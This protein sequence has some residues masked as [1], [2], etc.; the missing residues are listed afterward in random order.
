[1]NESETRWYQ[2]TEEDA[3]SRLD[4]EPG[5]LTFSEAEKRLEEHGP[6]EIEK[7]EE[8]TWI[9]VLVAQIKNPLILVL[10]VAAG[11]SLLAGEAVD[12]IVIV[13]VIVVN[14]LIGFVQEY[15]AEKSLEALQEQAAPEA[16]VVRCSVEDGT[17]ESIDV[18]IPSREVVPGDIIILSTGDKV[19][20]DARLLQVSSLEVD[21][22]ML[23]G[24]STPVQKVIEP[25]EEEAPVAEQQN[26]VFGG[27]T[28]TQ[29]H[30][31]ALVFATG[32][33][34]E[35]GKIATMIQE[36]EDVESPLQRQ[37]RDLSRKMGFL[38]LGVAIVTVLLGLIRGFEVAEIFLFA[39]A[40]AVSS[41]PAGLPAVMTIT[42]AVG[43]NRMAKRNA[44]I[45]R[46]QAV[47]TLGAATTICTDKTGTLTSNQMTVQQIS[48][49]HRSVRITGVG[50]EPE[51]R[52]E[53]DEEEVDPGEDEELHLAL[54]IGAL[55]N[56]SRLNRHDEEGQHVWEIR[57]DPT[58]GALVVAAAKAHQHKEN[59]EREFPRTDEIPFSSKTKFMATFHDLPDDGN[60]IRV[61]VKGAPETVLGLSAQRRRNGEVDSLS[62]SQEQELGDAAQ[63]MASQGLRVLGLAYLDIAKEDVEETRRRLEDGEKIMT[64]HALAGM[65]DP[66]RPEVPEAIERAKGAGMRVIMATG[67]HRLTAEAIADEID[68]LTEDGQVLTGEDV[69][70][71]DDEELERQVNEVDVFARVSPE[72]KH[73]MVEALRRSGEVVAMTGDG[74]ND[75]PALKAAEIGIAMGITGTDVTKET[76][77][78]VL[79]DDNFASIVNAVEEGRVVFQNIRKVVKLLIATNFGEILT[80]L[81]SIVLL[82]AGE[83][84]FLPVQILWV[85]LV[86]DGLLDVTLAMEPKEEDV[87]EHKP[88]DPEARIINLEIARNTLFVAL[89]MAIGTLG[90]FFWGFNDGEIAFA[91]T[92][93]F[94]TLAM[95]QVFNALNCRSL[96][97]S[98]FQ[99]GLFTN[100]YLIGAIV[101]SVLLQIG[102]TLIPFMQ[103]AMQTVPLSPA[104][105]LTIVLIASTVF[106]ADE[107]RKLVQ[108][109]A[110]ND[111]S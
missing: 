13:A 11:I 60:S 80:F 21:E 54:Q 34:T 40:A 7:G 29:G 63:E 87:M 6:N 107:L 97:K 78:M 41:V 28:I 58:E 106:I 70:H 104:N 100:P 37:V 46:L 105:W 69:E 53:I 65:I 23:T 25:M 77:E 108:R 64:F 61:L 76:A 10:F 49:D 57:G 84:I 103:T 86:T 52:F 102:V 38:A 92:M 9:E 71:L 96:D 82:P 95:F 110:S 44:I 24:E 59:L 15:R 81:T 33:D 68:I 88:R 36:T 8:T 72:H 14:T 18:S 62:E 90:I 99:L 27:S 55:C 35:M 75:A 30:G 109:R 47:D 39:L 83:L 48:F 32:S 85:N 16:E 17:E 4:S 94:T 12:A 73:R 5:G 91:R 26:L 19:P 66:A 3:F 51:G 89:F 98:L 20:A 42:L 111:R 45:R 93:A 22:S 43:V 50:F 31:R 56:D 67:D 79:T 101:V 1:M 74:V 2:L